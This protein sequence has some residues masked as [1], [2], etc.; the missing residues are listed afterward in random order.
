MVVKNK[1]INEAEKL[2]ND[3][4]YSINS[5]YDAEYEGE[6]IESNGKNVQDSSLKTS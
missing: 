6:L 2:K 3:E 5:D 4:I 1:N